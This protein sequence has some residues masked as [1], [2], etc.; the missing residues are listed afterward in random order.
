MKSE[1]PTYLKSD[2]ELECEEDG[3]FIV[4]TATAVVNEILL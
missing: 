3:N 2:D 1:C 4:F